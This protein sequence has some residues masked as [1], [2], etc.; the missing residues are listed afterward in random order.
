MG[1]EIANVMLVK[2]LADAFPDCQILQE[3]PEEQ[4]REQPEEDQSYV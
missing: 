3:S 4:P 1:L 2:A